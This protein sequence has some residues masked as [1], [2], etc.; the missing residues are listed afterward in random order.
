MLK[1]KHV[2]KKYNKEYI[3]NDINLT[4]PSKGLVSILGSSGS[5]KTTLLNIIGGIDKPTSGTISLNN[6]NINEL[7]NKELDWYHDKYVSFVFQQYNLINYLTVKDN[8]RLVNN[9]Y[10]LTLFKLNIYDLKNKKV[11][12]LS[13]GEK[14]RV[15]LA[16]CLLKNPKLLLCDE[17]TGALDSTN[18][19]FILDTLKEISKERLVIV[20]TH[21]EELANTYSDH[22]IRIKDGKIDNNIIVKERIQ[23][24]NVE[25]V[26]HKNIFK[27]IVNHVANKWKRNLLISLSFA[28]GL[29]S[30][31]LVL[32]ITNGFQASLDKEEKNTLSKYPI[33]ISK[34]SS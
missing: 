5:G 30:L 26:K 17:P 15:A 33:L 10:E 34:Y 31:G 21:N 24:I 22:I 23:N 28:I 13:G 11:S 27:V 32:S 12:E 4:L 6:K 9:N 3:L 19:I 7:N 20:I 18:S 25:K 16:R 29:I 14:Q 1:L 2:C 8:L